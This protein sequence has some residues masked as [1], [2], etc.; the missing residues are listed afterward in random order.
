MKKQLRMSYD[1]DKITEL[2]NDRKNKIKK[3]RKLLKEN[4]RLQKIKNKHL[5]E[6]EDMNA[7]GD[8]DNR[9]R[10]LSDELREA[11]NTARTSYYKNLEKKK[12][13][14]NKHENVVLLDKK[15]RKMQKLLDLKKKDAPA[16][17]IDTGENKDII[18]LE[19]KVKEATKQMEFEEKRTQIE[20]HRQEADISNMQHQVE[21]SA[22]KLREKEQEFRLCELK[23]KELKRQTRHN[24][25]K[26]LEYE[27]SSQPQTSREK[28]YQNRLGLDSTVG[29]SETSNIL[30]HFGSNGQVAE[31]TEENVKLHEQQQM[32]AEGEEYEFYSNFDDHVSE[33][34]I[35]KT[36]KK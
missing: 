29:R 24:A 25:L 31:L 27:P 19:E 14:I 36:P 34:Q 5:K 1:I 9:K 13:L 3:H 33:D 8:W 20:I 4:E 28:P 7:E 22:L 32:K 10:V 6:I 12:E 21:I 16:E 26:P 30:G 17:Q 2:E 35:K 11:K 23:I 15:I 18:K